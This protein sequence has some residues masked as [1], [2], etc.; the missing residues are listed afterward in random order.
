MKELKQVIL[1]RTDLKM[2]KGK[3]SAQCSHA[4]VESTLRSNEKIVE[5]WRKQGMKKAVLKVNR[6]EELFDYKFRAEKAGLTTA[7]ITDLGKTEIPTGTVTC[8]AIG[9]DSSEK[10][11]KITGKLGIL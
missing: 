9:P 7:L 2:S 8:L 6:R 10:I 4:S 5:K 11:N 3:V 1:V